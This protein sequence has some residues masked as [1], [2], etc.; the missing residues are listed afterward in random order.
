[1]LRDCLG[2]AMRNCNE[3][4]RPPQTLDGKRARWRSEAECHLVTGRASAGHDLTAMFRNAMAGHNALN[5]EMRSIHVA[6]DP[7]VI[8]SEHMAKPRA[9]T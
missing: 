4:D 6:K 7:Q 2:P 8:F 1:M 9:T 3:G 5:A